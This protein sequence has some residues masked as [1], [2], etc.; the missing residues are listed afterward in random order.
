M[1]TDWARARSTRHGLWVAGIVIVVGA[2]AA[3]AWHRARTTSGRTDG[4]SR[5]VPV[6]VASA[7]TQD[8]PIFLS[9]PGTVQA[10][11]T[12][13][14]RSQVDGKLWTVDFV[15]GQQ[16]RQGDILAEIDGRALKATMDQAIAKK[17]E[18]QAQLAMAQKDLDRYQVLLQRQAIPQ[19]QFDQQQAKVDQL[20]ATVSADQAA[21]DGAEVQLSYATIAA[22]I[23]GRVGIRQVDPGNIIHANDTN[24][25]TVLTL[26]KPAAV[27]FSLPQSKL[28]DAHEAML[29]GP[30]STIAL[31]QDGKKTLA[32]G[33][34]L[35]IDN[36]ID[37]STS[38]VRLKARFANDDERLW[39]GEFVRVRAQVDIRRNAVTIPSPALQRGPQGFYVWVVQPT[40][41][42]EPRDVD[43]MPVDENLTI[44]TKGLSP[45]D[46]VVVD[47]QSRLE[48]GAP[49]APRSRQAAAKPG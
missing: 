18:D 29:R 14:V 24:P 43:A 7:E 6:V 8:V 39:P 45:G 21:I 33:E 9:A 38:T 32:Q 42:A 4:A 25:L 48:S 30:L 27:I 15:E 47:G 13:S 12:V 17:G 49:V 22:P 11:N 3:A 34:V 28:S 1:R 26:V 20:N 31:D 35:L 5:A 40:N 36:Q 37:Q 46:R 44:V 23:G 41:T 10:W 19:E 16:V 2:L